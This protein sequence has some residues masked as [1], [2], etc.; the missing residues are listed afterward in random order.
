[1]VELGWDYF[2][3]G[4]DEVDGYVVLFFELVPF[5]IMVGLVPVGNTNPFF[6][7][8]STGDPV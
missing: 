2:F 4:I 5:D 3:I 1:V 6:V 7:V 8:Q